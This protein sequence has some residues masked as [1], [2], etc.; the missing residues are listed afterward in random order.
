MRPLAAVNSLISAIPAPKTAAP[1][2][3]AL[4][5]LD[6]SHDCN[7]GQKAAVGCDSQRASGAGL[8]V[9]PA[10][11]FGGEFDHVPQPARVEGELRVRRRCLFQALFGEVD[12][13]W[14]PDDVEQ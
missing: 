3:C 13:P 14:L 5:N 12:N 7:I 11:L 2:N 4:A 8:L 9:R 10:R 6:V 1:S